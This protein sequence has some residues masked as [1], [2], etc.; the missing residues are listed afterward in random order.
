MLVIPLQR[1][2][3]GKGTKKALPVSFVKMQR[4]A[5]QCRLFVWGYIASYNVSDHFNQSLVEF[6]KC[7]HW[8]S[9]KYATVRISHFHMLKYIVQSM[10]WPTLL[11]CKVIG[12]CN[13]MHRRCIQIFTPYIVTCQP[14]IVNIARTPLAFKMRWVRP[15]MPTQ[16]IAFLHILKYIQDARNKIHNDDTSWANWKCDP[17]QAWL[18][19][20]EVV[21]HWT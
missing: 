14:F 15:I 8:R 6:V 12:L 11:N 4:K 5:V 17:A 3:D 19:G 7:S 18:K 16:Y 13:R 1:F 9:T 2:V 10:L 21:Q 20:S